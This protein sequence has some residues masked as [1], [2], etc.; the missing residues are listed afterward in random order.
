MPVC[1]GRFSKAPASFGMPWA[2]K[3]PKSKCLCREGVVLVCTDAAA[4]GLDIPG[5]THVVQAEFAPS[6]VDFIHRVR[7]HRRLV[8][9]RFILS[10]PHFLRPRPDCLALQ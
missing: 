1:S 2:T 7:P 6:A 10:S 5:V 4:R 9:L 8:P 3:S